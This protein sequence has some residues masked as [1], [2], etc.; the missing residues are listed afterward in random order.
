MKTKEIIKSMIENQFNRKNQWTEKQISEW[1]FANYN[2]TRYIA[3]RVAK[4]F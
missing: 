2:C 4:E 1:V 3:N